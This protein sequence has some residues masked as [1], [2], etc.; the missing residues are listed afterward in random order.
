MK[1]LTRWLIGK[2]IINLV[3]IPLSIISSISEGVSQTFE[4]SFGW[5]DDDKISSAAIAADG[6]VIICGTVLDS[7]TLKEDGMLTKISP[8]GEVIWAVRFGEPFP[9]EKPSAVAVSSS[10]DII[11]AGSV[12]YTSMLWKWTPEGNPIWAATIFGSH[13]LADIKVMG[14]TA[15]GLCGT[16]GFQLFICATDTSGKLLWNNYLGGPDLDRYT[17]GNGI[18]INSIN[19]LTVCGNKS[20]YLHPGTASYIAA[21]KP[22]GS[23]WWQQMHGEDEDTEYARDLIQMPGGNYYFAGYHNNKGLLVRTNSGGQ[24]IWQ[25]YYGGNADES[26]VSLDSVASGGFICCGSTNNTS[27]GMWDVW[28]VRTDINGDTLWTRTFGGDYEDVGRYVKSLP[29]GGFLI[30]GYTNS[31]WNEGYDFYLIR[32]NAE[33]RVLTKAGISSTPERKKIRR[34]WH[35]TIRKK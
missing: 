25:K 11:V 29:D 12:G 23:L 33:G 32:T 3:I 2:I 34:V 18:T 28:L 24:A 20:I 35:T 16:A 5:M 21:V 14:D 7:L 13:H 17:T 6:S 19:G 15:Y 9:D 26:F 8:E 1:R 27:S 31:Y 22:D 4:I 30:A 10:G